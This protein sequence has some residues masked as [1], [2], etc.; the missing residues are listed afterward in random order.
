MAT[1]LLRLI[2]T[3]KNTHIHSHMSFENFSTLPANQSQVNVSCTQHQNKNTDRQTHAH[4]ARTEQKEYRKNNR[5]LSLIDTNWNLPPSIWFWFVLVSLAT[6]CGKITSHQS[7]F[8]SLKLRLKLT[9]RA[10]GAFSK[11]L[12]VFA[13]L[14]YIYIYST[15]LYKYNV[16]HIGVPSYNRLIKTSQV[17]RNKN[18]NS[19]S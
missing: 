17:P 7:V 19:H 18:T 4:H 12:V 1:I 16:C 8:R 15:I 10:N 2:E 13:C 6:S 14:L 5:Y 9:R 3:N 11:N